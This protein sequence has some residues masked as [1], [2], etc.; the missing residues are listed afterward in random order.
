MTRIKICGIT[1]MAALESVMKNDADFVGFVFVGKSPRTIT[2]ERAASL[3]N[4]LSTVQQ[5]TVTPTGLFVD[6]AIPY[7]ESVIEKIPLRLIQ[8]HGNEPPNFITALKKR[9]NLPVMK[10]L[11][12]RTED[13]LTQIE[14]YQCVSD[15]LLLDSKIKNKQGGTGHSFDWTLLENITIDIPWMLAGGLTTDNVQQAIRRTQPTAVDVS[16]GV[17]SHL[18]MKSPEKIADFIA[19]AR[20]TR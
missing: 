19:A 6:A 5:Q 18:G 8:L 2:P 13:D 20:Q 14:K 17:E 1:D 12:I 11:R 10:A 3:W 15:W 7:I 16:S 4:K 9:T